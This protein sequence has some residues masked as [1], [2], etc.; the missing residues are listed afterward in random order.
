MTNQTSCHN[1]EGLYRP[2]VTVHSRDPRVVPSPQS[3]RDF[4]LCADFSVVV[5]V[6]KIVSP[7]I[8]TPHE[9]VISFVTPLSFLETIKVL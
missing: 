2:T 7:I 3:L 4:K 5:Y 1:C 8:P 9:R 6:R